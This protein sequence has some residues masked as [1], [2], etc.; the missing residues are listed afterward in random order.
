MGLAGVYKDNGCPAAASYLGRPCK[1]TECPFENPPCLGVA[2]SRASQVEARSKRVG[3]LQS[4]GMTITAIATRLGVS[5]TTIY[6][7]MPR[8]I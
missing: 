8:S 2:R 3:E 6:R 5:R 7:S 4:R 1:C